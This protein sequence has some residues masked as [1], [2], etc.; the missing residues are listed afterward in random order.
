MSTDPYHDQ[1]QAVARMRQREAREAAVKWVDDLWAAQPPVE[2]LVFEVTVTLTINGRPHM[3]SA[4]FDAAGAFVDAV[5]QRLLER[6]EA[7][8][9]GE[10]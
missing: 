8:A 3:M 6:S 9:A 2:T 10:Q 1:A 7:G 5:R 4:P